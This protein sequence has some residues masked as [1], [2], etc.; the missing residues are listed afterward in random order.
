MVSRWPITAGNSQQWN[1]LA[2][3][4]SLVVL[5]I[6]VTVVAVPSDLGARLPAET[7]YRMG[8]TVG[9]DGAEVDCAEETSQWR[10]YHPHTADAFRRGC[11]HAMAEARDPR[12]S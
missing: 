12:G 7:A 6:V 8:V 4:V 11:L 2:L 10:R 5:V 1:G 9:S 3:G